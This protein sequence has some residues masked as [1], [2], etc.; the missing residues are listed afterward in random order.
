[1]A[2]E[3]SSVRIECR[4]AVRR[5]DKIQYHND[6][7]S[8]C[9]RR[10]D[11]FYPIWPNA[12]SSIVEEKEVTEILCIQRESGLLY[13]AIPAMMQKCIRFGQW[14]RQSKGQEVKK[15][16]DYG[17]DFYT[18]K[19][20]VD[21]QKIKAVVKDINIIFETEPDAVKIT[22]TKENGEKKHKNKRHV[23]PAT[24]LRKTKRIFGRRFG[25][26]F[27]KGWIYNRKRILVWLEHL[28]L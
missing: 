28:S 18:E 17:E 2:N 4:F 6:T 24:V 21:L 23:F 19:Q 3:E 15:K 22:Q 26:S 7:T 14:E 8:L 1:M 10:F 27:P 16:S 5:L 9:P 12:V 13:Q 11:S 20:E 25:R